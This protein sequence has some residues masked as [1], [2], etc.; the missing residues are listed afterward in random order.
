[1]NIWELLRKSDTETNT[2]LVLLYTLMSSREKMDLNFSAEQLCKT[3][4]LGKGQLSRAQSQLKKLGVVSI[5]P[6]YCQ[7]TGKKVCDTYKF[8]SDLRT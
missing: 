6:I 2:K 1:M 3:L 5:I 8:S 7:S 4:G